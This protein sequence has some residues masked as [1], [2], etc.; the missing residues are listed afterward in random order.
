MAVHIFRR[1][2]TYYWRRR[3]PRSLAICLDRPHLFMSLRTTSPVDQADRFDF[4]T[5]KPTGRIRSP[6][7]TSVPGTT[8]R[9]HLG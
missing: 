2:A 1:E 5:S 6:L 9:S 7:L 3:T 8:G 4:S